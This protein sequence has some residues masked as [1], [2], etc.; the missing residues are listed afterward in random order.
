MINEQKVRADFLKITPE[1]ESWGKYVMSK[2]KELAHESL[3]SS[4]IQIGPS[5]RVKD[6]ASYSEKVICRYQSDKPLL[7]TT[8]KVGVRMVLLT[9]GDVKCISEKIK[10][11]SNAWRFI[12][13]T[14][15][16]E[17]DILKN[18]EVFSYESDHFI[19]CPRE[20]YNTNGVDNEILTCEIQV[21]TILQH[22]YA[23]VSHDTI[24][25]KQLQNTPEIRR[26]LASSMA[27]I[28]EADRKIVQVYK[29]VAAMSTID[30]LLQE[31]LISKYQEYVPSFIRKLYDERLASM[32]VDIF[33]KEDL[34]DFM[35][36]SD[37]FFRKYDEFI[38]SA[39]QKYHENY[40]LFAQP[41]VLLCFY[42]V[43][44]KQQTTLDMWPYGHEALVLVLKSMN[45]TTDIL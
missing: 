7:D 33:T 14:R 36:Q 10:A 4:H 15:D 6:I 8:D 34:E 18:P 20:G 42:E 5:Y 17:Q 26:M 38:S 40:F 3:P 21:R 11:E 29:N 16:T 23:E 45:I 28:E 24:Y 19:V 13:R 32:F 2:L 37:D 1:L 41:I 30:N 31:K 39:L 35:G 44:K 12:K 9:T 27:F 25:K 43:K 22:A